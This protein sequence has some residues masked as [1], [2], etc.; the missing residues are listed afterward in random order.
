ME[1]GEKRRKIGQ[2]GE[3]KK[4]KREIVIMERGL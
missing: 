3:R 1:F 4:D 2:V